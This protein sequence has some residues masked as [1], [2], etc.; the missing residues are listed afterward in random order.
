MAA[1]LLEVRNLCVGF[2][3]DNGLL[4][5]VDDVDFTLD[6]GK[7]LGVVGES[8]CGKSV[9]AMSLMR[10][11]P[12]PAGVILGGEV[13]L[14]GRDLTKLPIEEMRKIRGNDI[15]M[16]FQEPMTAL[17]PV[18]RVGRQIIEAIGKQTRHAVRRLRSCQRR[19]VLLR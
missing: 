18:Q 8:G 3:T 13:R 11:L 6:A 10:L 19:E 7:T 1:P 14:E 16:I 9:T 2:Q 12:Q 4:T 17:N 5:A 15:A